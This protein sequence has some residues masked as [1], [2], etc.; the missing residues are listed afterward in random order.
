MLLKLPVI[1]HLTPL[2]PVQPIY[3]SLSSDYADNYWLFYELL[4]LVHRTNANF[5]HSLLS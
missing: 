2:Y 4:F 1:T 3:P 5:Y